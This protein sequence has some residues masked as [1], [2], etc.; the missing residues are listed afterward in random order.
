M[1][2]PIFKL[3]NKPTRIKMYRVFANFELDGNKERARFLH[4]G[5]AYKYA[6][7]LIDEHKLFGIHLL[8]VE[9]ET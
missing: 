6:A 5:D 9:C 7:N 1:T 4:P 3:V 2:A 8:E